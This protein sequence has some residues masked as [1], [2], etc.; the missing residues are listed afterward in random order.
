MAHLW[1]CLIVS[2]MYIISLTSHVCRLGGLG[3]RG[4][5]LLCR[6]LVRMHGICTITV[7]QYCHPQLSVPGG[8]KY[9]QMC[10]IPPLVKVVFPSYHDYKNN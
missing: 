1:M 9:T 8:N 6:A 10:L 5:I 4:K 7:I 2:F 3:G